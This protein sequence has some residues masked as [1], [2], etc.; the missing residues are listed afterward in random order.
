MKYKKLLWGG[1]LLI[2]FSYS[3]LALA[4]NP[5]TSLID[6]YK[7]YT[8]PLVVIPATTSPNPTPPNPP[9]IKGRVP[10]TSPITVI[11]SISDSTVLSILQRLIS[12]SDIQNKLRGPLGLQGIQG[13]KGSSGSSGGGSG[14]ID[15]SSF[16][17]RTQ[18]D[19]QLNGIFNSI[20]NSSQG[21]SESIGESVSTDLLSVSGNAT[22]GGNLTVTGTMT[23]TIVGNANTATALETARTIGGV[24]FD[25]TANIT[26]ASATGGFSVLGGDLSLGTNNLTMTGSLGSTG[27]RLTKGWFTDLEVSNAIVGSVTGNAG[28]VTNGV[29]TNTANSMSLI[30]PLTTL[31][32]SWIGPSSTTGIYF[33][34]GNVGIGTITPTYKLEIDGNLKA[35]SSGHVLSYS[36]GS[37]SVPVIKDYAGYNISVAKQGSLLFGQS[38]LGSSIS[39]GGD[40]SDASAWSAYDAGNSGG[41]TETVGY[42][43]S[44]FDGRYVYFVPTGN[45]GTAHG[46]VL[47]YDTS[48]DYDTASSWSAYDASAIGGLNTT[49]YSGGTF[50]GRYIYFAPWQD[51]TGIT[52]GRVL[53]LDT[54]GGFTTASSWAAYDA[55]ATGG[56]DV[57]GYRDAVF[58]GHYVYF[59][60]LRTNSE[61]AGYHGRVLRYDTT[62][63]FN[64]SGSWTVYDAGATGG[65]VTRGYKSAVFDGRYIYFVANNYNGSTQSN[66]ALRY[67]T[68]A[69]FTDSGSWVAFDA[70]AIGGLV[71]KGY[72]S[73]VFDGRYVYYVPISIITEYHGRVLRYD[74]AGSFTSVSSWSSFD[75]NNL[76]GANLRGYLGAVFDG[77][78]VTFVP[79]FKDIDGAGGTYHGTV[80]RYDTTQNFADT[81]SWSTYD[82]S[83]TG[84]LNTVGFTGGSFDGRYIYFVPYYDGTVTHARVLRYDTKSP[85]LQQGIGQVARSSNLFIN[86]LGNVGIGNSNP[87]KTLDVT[88][89]G[90]FTGKAS[91]IL[92]GTADPTASTTLVGINTFF[93]TELVV[94]DKITINAEIRTVTAIASDTSLTVNTAFTDTASAII[95]KLPAIFLSRSFSNN[96]GMVINYLGNVGI[97]TASP[98]AG[99]TVLAS[100]GT[101]DGLEQFTIGANSGYHLAMGYSEGGTTIGYLANAYDSSDSAR[102]DFRVGGLTNASTRIAILK[103]GNI[104]IGTISPTNLLSLS[105]TVARTIWME[106]NTTAVTAGQGLTLSSGGAIAGTADLAGGDLTLKSGI[107]TGSGSSAIHFYTATAGVSA[108]TDRTPTEKMTI[109]GS[110]FTGIGNTAPGTM[111]TVGTATT[112]TGNITVYGTGTTCV[113]GDGTGGTSCTSDIRLKDNVTDMESELSHIMA[114]RPVIFNW[115]D[116]TRDQVENMGLIAQEVQSIYPN[117]VRTIYDDYLGIDYT[118]LV[119]P[120]IKAIQELN[121]NLEGISGTITPLEGSANETFVTTFFN[122]LKTTISTWLADATNGITDIFAKK[123]T[124]DEVCL[125]DTN[126]TSC[127]TRT[128]LD[129]LLG[130]AGIAP[131][132]TPISEPIPEPILEPE[133][134]PEPE[135]TPAPISEPVPEPMPAPEPVPTPAPEPTPEPVPEIT[136]APEPTPTPTPE[137]LVETLVP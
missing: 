132:P 8:T 4:W 135:P 106:R 87:L 71:T 108:T 92:T 30:N 29:Y 118:T 10:E 125:K 9:L 127:Y 137:P 111:L 113:I 103:S 105:G 104:G 12:Q 95:T 54:Q 38:G 102:L 46:K 114:L 112:N 136:P 67:D 82:A 64:T 96:I 123:A 91:S 45:T 100:S 2:V 72:S 89:G 56:L 48:G 70:S 68:T 22:V 55:S 21:L 50:D 35:T 58:D 109:L 39:G 40:M 18:F 76:G 60:P 117:V 28:T 13:P 74:T 120:A 32:E 19:N 107:S 1:V 65:L 31:A 84:G 33:K 101:D 83:S 116:T 16:V 25:G 134:I 69:S 94:G 43:G 17:S 90:R 131:V 5:I 62:T 11:G 37:L 52:H 6:L 73:A 7:S 85:M 49:G 97:G 119:V 99:L 81:T 121:L 26:V 128:Q 15:T 86:S 42:W 20:E 79:Y 59:I 80:M 51:S 44:V 77:R 57:R 14:S 61:A 98:L 133:I 130:G 41:L 36:D 27:A 3:T 47:R 110:G 93:T 88:G 63:D 129:T 66:N 53:R 24:S 78:Y 122:N 115:K 75:G 34:D 126:G 23:R 124:L